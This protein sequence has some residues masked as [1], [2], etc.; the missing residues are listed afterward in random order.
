MYGRHRALADFPC[1]RG[2]QQ[3]PTTLT[4]M[5]K[6]MNEHTTDELLSALVDDE[7]TVDPEDGFRVYRQNLLLG[8]ALELR[9]T[10]SRTRELLGKTDFDE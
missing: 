8:V 5:K 9:S 3:T 10:F 4:Q 1:T 6:T 2:D 7:L